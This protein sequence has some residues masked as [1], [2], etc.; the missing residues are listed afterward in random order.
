MTNA[1]TVNGSENIKVKLVNGTT[2]NAKL[3]GSDNRTD[4]AVLKI[5]G[6]GPWPKAKLGDSSKIEVGEWVI[7]IGNPSGL[8]N[9]V[10][11][12]IISTSNKDFSK[13][14]IYDAKFNLIQTDAVINPGN[15]GGPLLNSKG[16]VIGINTLIRSGT[17]TGAGLSYAIPINKTKEIAYQIINNGKVI[18][19]MIGINLID[20][21]KSIVKVGYVVPNSPAEKSGIRINDITIKVGKKDINNSSDVINE[22]SENENNKPIDIQ[23]LSDENPLIIKEIGLSINNNLPNKGVKVVNIIKEGYTVQGV[24]VGDI[25][26]EINGKQIKN[27]EHF[28]K[29]IN[30]AISIKVILLIKREGGSAYIGIKI[31]K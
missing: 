20:E 27:K 14:G 3:I 6:K 30:D 7:A 5:E 26:I 13:L 16:E 10:T 1:H 29:L 25:I 23:K 11:L 2:Y 22:I 9:T 8:G 18:H 12:G 17:G 19:P 15:T 31:K 28:K 21:P 4:L 24:R